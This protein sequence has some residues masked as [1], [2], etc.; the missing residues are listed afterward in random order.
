MS[1]RARLLIALV[2][3]VLAGLTVVDLLTYTLVSRAQIDQV[4]QDLERAHPPIERAASSGPGSER[5]IRDA[6]PGF[7]AELRG[8]DGKTIVAVRLRGPGEDDDDGGEFDHLV[9]PSPSGDGDDEAV[10][11]TV[12][13]GGDH[14]IRVR[15]SR[16]ENGGVLIIGRSLAAIEDT[17]ERLLVVLIAATGGALIV[18]GVLGAWLVRIGLRPLTA[19]ERAA[20]DITESDLDERVPGENAHTEV[21]RLAGSI[22]TMLGRLSVSFEQREADLAALQLSEARMRHF[23]ADASHEL[24]TPLAATLAYAELFDRGAREHPDDL[25]RAMAGIRSETARMS[26][27]V[28]DLLLLAQLDEGR[29]LSLGSVDLTEIVVEAID[30]ARTLAPEHSVTLSVDDVVA[31]VADASR[32]RQVLDNLLTNVRTHAGPMSTCSVRVG[33]DGADAVVTVADDGAGMDTSDA[34]RAFDR[35]HR[36]DESRTRTS[37]GAGLGLSIVAAILA[38]HHGSVTIDSAPGAGTTVTVRLPAAVDAASHEETGV[39]Q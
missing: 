10:F 36:A 19:V 5:A 26:M 14:S 7:Y 3:A 32:L 1:L 25:E 33:L 38:A 17:R 16:Q 6:A 21:G 27:L 4:D 15:V 30:A 13:S 39:P 29:P 12:P 22:N 9:V 11:A 18:A 2:I 24:R 34:G 23:V 8:S 35:F 37:G 31:V 28:E 20:N